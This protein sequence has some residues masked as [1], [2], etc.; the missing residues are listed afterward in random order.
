[1]KG[2]QDLTIVFFI[3]LLKL[4]LVKTSRLKKYISVD[5][6]KNKSCVLSQVRY[7]N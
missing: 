4:F 5:L 1:M 2:F 7:Q 6:H 3:G